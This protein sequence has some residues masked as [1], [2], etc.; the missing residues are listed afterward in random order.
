MTKKLLK[1]ASIRAI[2]T[3]G[4]VF[5]GYIGSA[6]VFSEVDWIVLASTVGLAGLTSFVMSITTG[7]PEV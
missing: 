5:V 6:T 3:M 1:C 2:K 4:Q 7:L